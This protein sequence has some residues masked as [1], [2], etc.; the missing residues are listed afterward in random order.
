MWPAWYTTGTTRNQTEKIS[1]KISGLLVKV[2]GLS[3]GD[4]WRSRRL[5]VNSR[6]WAGSQQEL[7]SSAAELGQDRQDS[8][9]RHLIDHCQ[10]PLCCYLLKL[11]YLTT[12][13]LEDWKRSPRG[14]QIMW[15]K[16]VLDDLK[17]HH[18]TLTEAV[19]VAVEAVGSAFL[20]VQARTDNSDH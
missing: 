4:S 6:R 11:T 5:R 8:V 7:P 14:R 13:S 9:C 15:L 20:E 19:S 3:F 16:T 12:Y 17:F 10:S 18:L 1:V 2:F